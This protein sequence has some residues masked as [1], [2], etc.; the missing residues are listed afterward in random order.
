MPRGERRTVAHVQ[1]VRTVAGCWGLGA[2]LVA[3]LA[4]CAVGVLAGDV[5]V[6]LPF[7]RN[8]TILLHLLPV[9]SAMALGFGLVDRTPELTLLAPAPVRLPLLRLAGTV[10]V[11]LPVLVTLVAAGWTLAGASVV[12][13]ML[14]LAALSAALLRLW[15]WVPFFA[16]VVGWAQA[17]SPAAAATAGPGWLLVSL[18]V[19]AAGGAAYVLVE[20]WRVRRVIHGDDARTRGGR[21]LD[22]MRP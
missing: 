20:A 3:S 15:Y 8:K 18:G 10:A 17:R 9:L 7:L 11:A 4:L 19:L 16:I 6:E 13:A 14:G 21:D 5:Y 22:T 1:A 2:A 12:L